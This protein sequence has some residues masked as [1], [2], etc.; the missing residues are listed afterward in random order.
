MKA[1]A[2]S[3]AISSELLNKAV[4]GLD[5]VCYTPDIM[6]EVTAGRLQMAT[7]LLFTSF[8]G[9][10][11]ARLMRNVLSVSRCPFKLSIIVLFSTNHQS[12]HTRLPTTLDINLLMLALRL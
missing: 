2:A 5:E 10:G 4:A 8:L 12:F 7:P 11:V 1:F 6:S 9:S 3:R